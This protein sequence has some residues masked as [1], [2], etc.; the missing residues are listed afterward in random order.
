MPCMAPGRRS[1]PACCAAASLPDRRAAGS[2]SQLRMWWCAQA[3]EP[4]HVKPGRHGNAWTF[5]AASLLIRCPLERL[6]TMQVCVWRG[7]LTC[8]LSNTHRQCTTEWLALPLCCPAPRP[9]NPCRHCPPVGPCLPLPLQIYIEF[10]VSHELRAEEAQRLPRSPRQA[11]RQVDEVC[12]AWAL[13]SLATL[14]S[15]HE[16]RSLHVP[17]CGGRLTL[18]RGLR[19][20][21]AT[22][23]RAAGGPGQAKQVGGQS[24]P[25]GTLLRLRFTCCPCP[26]PPRNNACARNTWVRCCHAAVPC[27]VRYHAAYPALH[28]HVPRHVC[29]LPQVC[30]CGL[31]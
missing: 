10:N 18:R 1:L 12:V 23:V 8:T 9:A 5:D 29:L 24:Q 30:S 27:V 31:S 14:P 11:A 2:R 16:A 22:A 21:Q 28:Q 13:V 6:K 20:C 7:G 17:L 25:F 15:L 19:E 4:R 26:A 3:V